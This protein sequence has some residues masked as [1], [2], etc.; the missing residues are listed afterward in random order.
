M[1]RRRAKWF[2]KGKRNTKCFL[3]LEKS[4]HDRKQISEIRNEEG[5]IVSNQTGT[6]GVLKL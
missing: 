1:V 3:N 6:L 5:N 2:E 4:S